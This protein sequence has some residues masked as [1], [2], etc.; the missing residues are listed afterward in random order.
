MWIAGAIVVGGIVA[1]VGA[2]SSARTSARASTTAAEIAAEAQGEAS[3]VQLDAQRTQLDYLEDVDRLPREYRE[4]ALTQLGEV[5][6][7]P[8]GFQ[9]P[10]GQLL[11]QARNSEMFAMLRDEGSD[12]ILRSASAT[13]GLRSGGT[14]ES[15]VDNQQRALMTSYQQQQEQYEMG[16]QGVASLAN[17]PLNTANISNVMGDMGVTGAAGITGAADAISQGQIA[18]AQAEALGMQNVS[19]AVGS[20]ISTTAQYLAN[21]PVTPTPPPASTQ[22]IV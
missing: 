19:S 15:L 9:Y 14:I 1:A 22:V 3:E 4:Q 10:E 18:A 12:A 5:Y 21:R 7:G 16:L 17:L 20:G 6:L 8:E 11:D 13:G 2:S